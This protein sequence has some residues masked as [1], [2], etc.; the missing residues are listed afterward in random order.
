MAGLKALLI[1]VADASELV[2]ARTVI[3]PKRI[4]IRNNTKKYL[5]NAPQYKSLYIKPFS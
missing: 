1:P 4:C 5:I 2:C 3:G